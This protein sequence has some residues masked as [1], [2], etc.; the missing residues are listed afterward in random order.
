MKKKLNLTRVGSTFGTLSFDEKFFSRT[1]L[2]FTPYWDSKP[3]NAIYF[4]SPGVYT[5]DKN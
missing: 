4:D 1:L 5:S 3:T 2:G